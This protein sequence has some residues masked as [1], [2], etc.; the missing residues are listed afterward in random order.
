MESCQKTTQVFCKI[1]LIEILSVPTGY[2]EIKQEKFRNFELR[3]LLYASI[4]RTGNI[5]IRQK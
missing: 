5:P 4:F 1:I 3:A 2:R